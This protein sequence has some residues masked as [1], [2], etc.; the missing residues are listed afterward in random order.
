MA[1]MVGSI[2]LAAAATMADAMSCGKQA[3]EQMTRTATYLAQLHMRLS[4]LVMR[5]NSIETISD[6][7]K[8]G[9]KVVCEEGI[10]T[11]YTDIA[12]NILYVQKEGEESYKYDY[13]V[14]DKI[15]LMPV[16][17]QEKIGRAS[18]RERV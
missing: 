14:A 5:A 9:V 8:E 13:K 15:T 11:I 16:S 3:T 7:A 1:L 18:C 12:K 6:G 17:V 2:V 4:D 10:F